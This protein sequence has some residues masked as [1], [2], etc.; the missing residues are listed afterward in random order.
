MFLSLCPWPNGKSLRTGQTLRITRLFRNLYSM[1][2]GDDG[3]LQNHVFLSECL[4]NSLSPLKKD[5]FIAEI[6]NIAGTHHELLHGKGYPRRL[7]AA[8]IHPLAKILIVADKFESATSEWGKGIG[9][10]FPQVEAG[11]IS[12][13]IFQLGRNGVFE[14]FLNSCPSEVEQFNALER[15]SG[16]ASEK[17]TPPVRR[18]DPL[19]N[20][21]KRPQVMLSALTA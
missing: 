3:I 13:D 2:S 8:D 6:A 7:T 9:S 20:I 14:R 11:A 21:A 16:L 19:Q 1:S 17:Y 12:S 5:P 15:G 4:I 10:L 18:D